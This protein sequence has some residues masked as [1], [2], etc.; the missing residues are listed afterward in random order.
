MPSNGYKCSHSSEQDPILKILDKYTDHPTIKL[1]QAKNNSQIKIRQI[2]IEEVKKTFQ[3]LARKYSHKKMIL[4]PQ[5]NVDFFANYTCDNINDSIHSSKFPNELKQ[6]DI[7][8][9]IKKIKAF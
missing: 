7:V 5:K 9:Y 3:S 4:K 2:D 1:I 8:R 6:A